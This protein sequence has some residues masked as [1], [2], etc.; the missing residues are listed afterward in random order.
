MKLSK[1][2]NMPAD[3]R[4][5]EPLGWFTKN[6][7][8]LVDY[9]SLN[10]GGSISPR[11]KQCHVIN[12]QK[13]GTLLFCMYL[14]NKH[15]NWSYTAL[16]YT[17]LHG[18]YGLA[19]LIKERMF[20][21]PKWQTPITMP[22]VLVTIGAVLGPYWLAPYFLISSGAERPAAVICATTI[23]Y[24]VGL[25]IMMG[26]DAQKYFVLKERKGLITDGFFGLCRHP[27]Y[28]GEMLIYGSLATM[29]GVPIAWAPLAVV[30]TGVFLYKKKTA[31]LIPG[32]F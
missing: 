15:D 14:I 16:A 7:L 12:A 30:W 9:L 19:W 28:L 10:L 23:S 1:Q 18:S 21:D 32:I 31:F 13:G 26:A 11:I 5:K 17:A 27:N 4:P 6:W 20:P 3:S 22:A 24:V 2:N 8:K 29:S 25:C